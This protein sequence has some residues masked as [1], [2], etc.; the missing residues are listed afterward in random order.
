VKQCRREPI[1][2]KNQHLPILLHCTITPHFV[3]AD[4]ENGSNRHCRIFTQIPAL[5]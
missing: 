3:D 5:H 1:R 4:V 2:L